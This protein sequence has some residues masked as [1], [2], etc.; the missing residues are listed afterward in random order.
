MFV[1][2]GKLKQEQEGISLNMLV[3]YW[4]LSAFE[5]HIYESWP[6][7]KYDYN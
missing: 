2:Q 4:I 6:T 1:I 7:T 5:T 3:H